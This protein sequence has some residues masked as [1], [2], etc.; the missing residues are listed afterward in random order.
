MSGLTRNETALDTI[1]L[2]I[3]NHENELII[4]G[5]KDSTLLP[6]GDKEP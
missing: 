3:E 2:F 4:Q 1:L 6:S 5:R